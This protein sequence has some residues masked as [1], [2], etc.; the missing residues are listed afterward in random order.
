MNLREVVFVWGAWV[1]FNLSKNKG[2]QSGTLLKIP[3]LSPSM[4]EFSHL[5]FQK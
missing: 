5:L 3:T 1:L 2:F 4:E